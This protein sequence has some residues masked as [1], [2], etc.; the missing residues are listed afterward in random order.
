M[1]PFVKPYRWLVLITTL[2]TIPVGLMDATIAWSLRPYM[3]IVMIEKPSGY[4][5]YLPFLIIIFGLFQGVMNYS[6]TYLNTWLMQKISNDIKLV[7]FE[8]L[9][10]NDSS[11][12]DKET[13]GQILFRFNHDVDSSCKGLILNLK[14]LITRVISSI[15][16]IAVIFYNSWILATISVAILLMA[17]YP[18]TTIRKKIESL[19]DRT[20][21]SGAL[22]STHYNET[23][24]G[25][26]VIA[27]YN[28]SDYQK[29]RFKETLNSVFNIGINMT[30]KT[31]IISP[32]MHFIV[33]I[34]IALVIWVGSY[35]IITNQ[36][37]PGSFVSSIAA[38]VMLYTPIKGLGNNYSSIQMALLAM[39]RV[40]S[41]L[42]NIPSITDKKNAITLKNVVSHIEYKDV[43]FEYEKGKSVLKNINLKVN[44][45]EKIAIVGGSGG[46]KTTLASLLPR[47][48]D[49]TSG[50]I[51]IDGIDIRNIN[52]QSLRENISIVFQDNFL[53][54]GSI[55]ENI[56]LGMKHISEERLQ[57][58]LQGSCLEE[59]INSLENGMETEIGERGILLSGGQRQRVAI[60]RAFL[61]NAPILIL[62]EATSSLDNQSEAV[63]QKA[64]SNLME[65]RTV[66]II[67]HRLTTI[68]NA[69]KIIV[70]N[71]GEVAELGTHDEL[72]PQKGGVYAS[73]YHADG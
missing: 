8:K 19:M 66:F 58:V 40:W 49:V 15:A 33:S 32:L 64:I 34:G 43:H 12:F 63:V 72:L 45:G 37:S 60:A 54:S 70:I 44:I 4:V 67:A 73:L 65:D 51:S 39:E 13:S 25:N 10:K 30:K 41:L 22:V 53:F 16:L 14:T 18:L 31:G 61:K 7:L 3:D 29:N 5:M 50:V 68:K 17:L 21:F 69:D 9:M 59:F 36:I 57:Q 2:I 20:I 56:T 24:H 11:F 48:Y 55:R 26:K 62:D 27:S 28:L 52:L 47:F 23:F 46:G 42:Q 38:L 71:H 1:W 6:A 35:L